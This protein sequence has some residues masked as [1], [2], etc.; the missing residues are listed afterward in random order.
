MKKWTKAAALA[1]GALSL[2][3]AAIAAPLTWTIN[4][5]VY[6][7]DG[8][9]PVTATG[10]FKYDADTNTFSDINI[11]TTQGTFTDATVYTQV[12]T[13]PGC[14]VVS[15]ATDILLISAPYS[16]DMTGDQHMHL[17]LQAPMTNGGGSLALQFAG[18]EKCQS[19]ACIMGSSGLRIADPGATLT[20]NAVVAPGP[21]A[22][23]VPTLSQWGL[24][25]LTATFGAAAFLRQ[26]R[27]L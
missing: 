21:G 6:S 27:K 15:S 17:K 23:P 18:H 16:A 13:N 14:T 8:P 10:S 2:T 5:L 3:T 1:I 22:A 24:I 4:N 12:C 25:L 7:N 26:R 19:P 11:S 9:T 20:A